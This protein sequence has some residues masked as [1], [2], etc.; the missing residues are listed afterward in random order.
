MNMDNIT[1]KQVMKRANAAVELEIERLK[2]LDAPVIIYDRKKQVIVKRNSDGTETEVGKR[3][4]KGRCSFCRTEWFR[5]K[6]VYEFIE[7]S[8]GLYQCR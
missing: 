2:V 6:Y 4:R 8:N 3:L 5:Q 1:D 7:T